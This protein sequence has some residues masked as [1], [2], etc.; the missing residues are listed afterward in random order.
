MQFYPTGKSLTSIVAEKQWSEWS[1]LGLMRRTVRF[2]CLVF[3]F[4]S[5]YLVDVFAAKLTFN[6]DLTASRNQVL[7]SHDSGGP[8]QAVDRL[9]D[10]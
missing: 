4:F 9:Q 2:V 10:L 5:L 6:G 8:K 7:Q 3:L 1:S